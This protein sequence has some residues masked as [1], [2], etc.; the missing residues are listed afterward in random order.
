MADRRITSLVET[1]QPTVN[2]VLPIVNSNITKKVTVDN[3]VKASAFSNNA[4]R[5]LTNIDTSITPNTKFLPVQDVGG[6]LGSVSVQNLYPIVVNTSTINLTWSNNTRNLQASII[7]GSINGTHLGTGV[8]Q[9]SAIQDGA[10]TEAKIDPN[11]KIRGATGGGT[12]RVFYENDTVVTTAYTITSGKNAMTAGPVTINDG[13]AV[14][15]PDGST[16]TVV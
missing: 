10:I 13:I 2:D 9:T 6:T 15:V 7:A 11:A 5:N 14:T 3:L 1:L 8:I 16:W 12:D 4:I